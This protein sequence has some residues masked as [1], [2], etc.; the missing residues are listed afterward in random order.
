MLLAYDL[1]RQRG[2]FGGAGANIMP[3]GWAEDNTGHL[4]SVCF[5]WCAATKRCSLPEHP[6]VPT[7]VAPYPGRDGL[8][9]APP[10]PAGCPGAGEEACVLGK[11]REQ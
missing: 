2:Q 4:L 9:E 5:L 3:H 8:A 6:G 1:Q 11:E 10:Q 7:C